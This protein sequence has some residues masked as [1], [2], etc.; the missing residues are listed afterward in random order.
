ML[1][2]T[3]SYT[4]IK[5]SKAF[6]D[7]LKFVMIKILEK[8]LNKLR[9]QQ[10][11][12][13]IEDVKL[14]NTPKGFEYLSDGIKYACDEYGDLIMMNSTILDL[15]IQLAKIAFWNETVASKIE[16]DVIEECVET[17]IETKELNNFPNIAILKMK[18]HVEAETNYYINQTTTCQNETEGNCWTYLKKYH[19]LMQLPFK[20]LNFGHPWGCG[21]TGLG[22]GTYL[23]YFS[24]LLANPAWNH[25]NGNRFLMNKEMTKEEKELRQY[26]NLILNN[27][28]PGQ[29][30]AN[31]SIWE[32]AKYLHANPDENIRNRKYCFATQLQN[33]FNCWSRKSR[34]FMLAWE[35]YSKA[36]LANS[37]YLI[38]LEGG[39]T[40]FRSNS[41][42]P[43]GQTIH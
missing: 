39:R 16:K 11:A 24:R 37:C 19:S 20:V 29:Q 15:A 43:N 33:E 36:Y 13:D 17:F 18:D 4:N 30:L 5:E 31:I 9:E 26:M 35:S 32:L 23:A 27:L 28:S 34:Y 8:L 40:S 14:Y 1:T 10:K 21:Y 22:F 41:P 6:R 12:W 42:A 7:K 38:R 2:D 3:E 25:W